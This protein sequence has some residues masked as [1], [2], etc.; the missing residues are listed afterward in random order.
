MIIVKI[1]ENE[2]GGNYPTMR[3]LLSLTMCLIMAISLLAGCSQASAPVGGSAAGGGSVASD[4]ADAAI[5]W[6]YKTADETKA[7][8]DTKESVI[9]LDSR[10]DDMYTKGHIPGAYHVPSYPVDTQELEKVLKDAVPNLQGD[11]PIVIVCK[12]G[13]KGAKRAISVLQDEGIAAERLFILE[14]GGE[15]W[16]FPEYTSTVNDSVVP[17]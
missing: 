17:K 11:D 6:Q 14:G 13:N 9:I 8:L 2:R 7:M 16:K 1:K 12:T 10:P 5:N 3:K 15:G 4:R